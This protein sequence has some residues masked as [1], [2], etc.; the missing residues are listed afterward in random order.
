[1][2]VKGGQVLRV[3]RSPGSELELGARFSSPQSVPAPC[4]AGPEIIRI[5]PES[6]SAFIALD[7]VRP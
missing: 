7:S 6:T 4:D 3:H 2:Q 1:M 5:E